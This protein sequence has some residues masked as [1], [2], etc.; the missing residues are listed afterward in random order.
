MKVRNYVEAIEFCTRALVVKKTHLK[1]LSRRA[2]AYVELNMLDKAMRDID[3]AYKIEPENNDIVKQY[4]IIK[5]SVADKKSE[6]EIL[7]L[8]KSFQKQQIGKK[9]D[10]TIKDNNNDSK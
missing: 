8:Q 1:A 2:Q 9:V 10:E 4:K 3:F 6:Q 5:Q 7:E